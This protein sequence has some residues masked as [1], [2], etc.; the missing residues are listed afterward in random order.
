ME[1]RKENGKKKGERKKESKGKRKK[2]NHV[3]WLKHMFRMN[4]SPYSLPF[5]GTLLS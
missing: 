1:E 5:L 2:R 3:L 4:Y